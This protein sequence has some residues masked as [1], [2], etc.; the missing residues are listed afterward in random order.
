MRDDVPVM[1][2]IPSKSFLKY[3]KGSYNRSGKCGYVLVKT[4]KEHAYVKDIYTFVKQSKLMESLPKHENVVALLGISEEEMPIY[5]YH[6]YVECLT[7]RNY[8][9]RNYQSSGLSASS[10]FTRNSRDS[11]GNNITIELYEFAEDVA[12]GMCFLISQNFK[13]PALS[14][15]KVLL[16]NSG[17]CKLY[18]IWPEEMS[19]DRIRHLLQ[20]KDPPLA[21]MAP[22]CIFLGQYHLNT[23]VWS[24]GVFM[25]ELFS[26]GETPF[27]NMSTFEIEKEVRN[28]RNLPMPPNCPG[29]IFNLMLS[30]WNKD[31]EKRPHFDNILKQLSCLLQNLQHENYNQREVDEIQE[32]NSQQYHK[33]FTL[34]SPS[35]DR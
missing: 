19:S 22:E 17:Q 15:R 21:W 23:D 18:D 34:E 5:S 4:V 14:L 24:Y 9:L 27:K 26:F 11:R 25:W 33:Y 16:S 2:F 32:R 20:R 3:F 28:S 30:S 1:T 10:S 12:S 8:M 31:A 35:T 7:L 6:E 13:H 29:A